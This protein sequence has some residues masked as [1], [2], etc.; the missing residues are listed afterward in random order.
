MPARQRPAL[1]AS[2]HVCSAAVVDLLS[3]RPL[4]T[5]PISQVS[6]DSWFISSSL[7]SFAAEAQKDLHMLLQVQLHVLV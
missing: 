1:V 5:T 6:S 7:L 4:G 2:R 3:G